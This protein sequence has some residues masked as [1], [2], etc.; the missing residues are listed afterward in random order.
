MT[1][2]PADDLAS[3]E[4]RIQELTKELSEAR[5]QQAATSEILRVISSSNQLE[6]VF[7]EIAA[8]AARLCDAHDAAIFRADGN[9]L[10]LV[11][12][13]GPIPNTADS[14]P[15]KRGI[16]TAHAIL[17]RRTIQV[18]D[19]QAETDAYPESS[20]FAR[21]DGHR[22]LLAVPLIRAA[23]AIG[24]ITIRRTEARLFSDKQIALL[25]IFA[26][27]A[28]IAIENTRLFEAERT[29]TKELAEALEQQTA[30]SEVLQVISGSPGEL[31]PV[32]AA[33]LENAVRICGASFGNLLLYDGEKFRHVAL[34]NAPQ[35]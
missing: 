7:A 12:H 25:E 14:T 6:R 30:T 24:T 27:Q 21:R 29:R 17:D 3:A 28:V 11:G 1:A 16:V 23:I 22:T 4:R 35:A 8:S 31:E 15:L 26:D 19:L 18:A 20:D 13:H 33:M 10:R 2:S 5:E 32:F 34:H 9:I